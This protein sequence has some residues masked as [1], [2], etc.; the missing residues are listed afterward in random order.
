MVEDYF[1]YR[2]G[3]VDKPIPGGNKALSDYLTGHKGIAFNT[4]S[5]LERKLDG[6]SEYLHK[7]F[8]EK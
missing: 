6:M 4:L 3:S 7:K 5:D 8:G 2:D 1:T